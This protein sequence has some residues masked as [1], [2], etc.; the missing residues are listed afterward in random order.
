MKPIAI[1]AIMTMTIAGCGQN[2]VPGPQVS[3][4]DSLLKLS[5][6]DQAE[7]R[8]QEHCPVSGE[9]LGSMGTP[10]KV[11]V[12]GRH[13]FICCKGCENKAIANFDAYY[14]KTAAR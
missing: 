14:E 8:K 13:F 2:A 3:I 1:I 5:V 7:A 12:Q 4:D 6:D 10:Q 9:A 11:D